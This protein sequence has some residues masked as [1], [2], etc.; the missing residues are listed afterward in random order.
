MI[1]YIVIDSSRMD[2]EAELL[3]LDAPRRAGRRA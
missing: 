1:A 2:F 3:D